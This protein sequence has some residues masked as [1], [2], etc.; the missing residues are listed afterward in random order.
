MN[1]ETQSTTPTVEPCRVASPSESRNAT[2]QEDSSRCR[3]RYPNGSRCRISAK[4]SHSGLCS[5]HFNE[6][7]GINLSLLPAPSDSEDLSAE[8]LTELSESDF[9]AGV[10]TNLFLARL[11]ILVTKGRITPRRAAVLAYISNQL[12]HSHRA[13]QKEEERQHTQIIMDLPRPKR[14]WPEDPERAAYARLSAHSRPSDTNAL[15]T[16][17]NK[18]SS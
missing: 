14:D 1:P 2:T 16:T 13:I 11:L 3:H 8:L 10:P 12:L 15:N 4:P 9:D 6:S 7:R 18:E 5:R 17:N